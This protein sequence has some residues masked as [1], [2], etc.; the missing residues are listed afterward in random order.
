MRLRN[1]RNQE[2]E[3]HGLGEF[4]VEPMEPRLLLS[5]EALG[6]DIGIL[7][8][9][10]TE[11]PSWDLAAAADWTAAIVADPAE[12]V[13]TQDFGIKA[14]EPL[15]IAAFSNGSAETTND[16]N[17]LDVLGAPPQSAD[18]DGT[19]DRRE[20][21]F[22]DLKVADGATLL[23]DLAARDG[24]QI[25]QV[26][27]LNPHMDGVDQITSVL[28]QHSQIDA[29]HIVTHGRE[30]G[31]QLGNSWLTWDRVSSYAEAI[32]GWGDALSEEADLL[33]YGCNLAG[34]AQG[35]ALIE[36][37][38]RL[39]GADVAASDDLTGHSSLGGDWNLE[40]TAGRIE[41]GVAFSI[42]AQ[43]NWTGQ[44]AWF[45]ADTGTPLGGATGGADLFVGDAGND[46]G[47]NASGG[48]DVLYG[49]DG[50]DDLDGSSD[51]DLLLGG[52]GIDT[53]IGQSGD[54]I[55]LGG[56]GDDSL[57]GG[58]DNDILIG[59]GGN[60]TLNGG[61]ND[62]LFLFSGAQDGDVYDVDG[63][64]H[65]DTIDV[66]E[67]GVGNVILDS[68]TITVNLGGGQSFV[69]N[70][71]DVENI[72]RAE[73]GGNRAAQADAGPDQAVATSSLVT[74]DAS[75]SSDPDLDA[76]TYDWQQIEGTSWVTLSDQTAASPTFT[77]PASSDVLTFAV[78]VSDGIT[79]DVDIV[80][81][82][83][84]PELIWVD[85][86]SGK[87]QGSDLDGSN[88][89]DLL[90]GL[91]SP[92]SVAVDVQAGKVY[93]SDNVLNN[94]QRA[95]LDGTGVE[96]I[97]VSAPGVSAIDLNIAGGKIYWLEEGGGFL[98]RANLDGTAP[99]TISGTPAVSTGLALDVS[100]DKIYFAEKS[101]AQMKQ[102]SLTGAGTGN[103]INSGIDGPA[104][105]A[106]DFIAGKIYWS[107]DT[108][109]EILRANL[110]DGSG[111]E[112]VI[113]GLGV[114][115][116]LAVDSSAGKIYW[117]DDNTDQLQRANLDGTGI[118]TLVP[119][120]VTPRDVDVVGVTG[121]VANTAPTLTVF[122]APVDATAE[123]TEVEVTFA[124]LAAQG[125]E[126]DV[127][128]TVDA[129]VVKAVST[130]TLTIGASAGTATLW[131]A[132]TNDTIDATNKAYWAPATNA[133]GTLNAFTAV[134]KDDDGAESAAPVQV[135]VTVSDVNDAP[136]LA[137]DN[138]SLT[139]IDEDNFTSGG[140]SVAAIVVDGSITDDDGA[141]V[142][143]IAITAVDESNGTWQYS[144]DNGGTW[145]DVDN[146]SLAVNHALLLDGT[147][148]GVSTQRLRFVPN[149]DYTGSAS[150]TFRA[151]D[152]TSG[153]AGTYADTST[154]GDPSA[155]SSATDT[156]S[157]TINAVNDAPTLSG[158]PYDLGSTDEDTT[159]TGVQ[160]STILGG[161]TTG[162][163]DGDTLGLAIEAASGN[164]TWQYSTD[165]TDGTDGTWTGFG[166][167]AGNSALL[168]SNSNWL[169][170]VPDGVNGESVAV[171][172]H[173]WDGATGT[174]STTVTPSY[175]DPGTGGS[176]TAYS[177]TTAQASL[178]VSDMNDP[179][180]FTAFVGVVDTTG[181]DTEVEISFDDL[182]TWG[183]ENDVDGTVEAFVVKSLSS[184]SLKIGAD[185]ASAT[186]WLL[187]IN[188]TIDATT[189]AYWTPDLAANG[190][191]N[192]FEVVAKD[193]DNTE[194]SIN[195]TAQVTVAGANNAPTLSGGLYDLGAT[196]EDTTSTGVR[197]ATI[198]G[199]LTTG[200]ADGDT[201]GLAIEAVNGNGTW[202]YSTDSTDG[203]DGN[204]SGF[205]T[206]AGNSALLLSNSSWIRYVPDGVDG[207]TVAVTFHA[208]DGTTG[209]ASTPGTA[210]YANPGTGGG[211][212][213]YSGTT[214]QAS[215]TVSDVNDP[216]T[217]N[218]FVGVVDMTGEDTEV[219]ITF[220]DLTGQGDENDIDGTVDAF[221]VQG[222]SSG[223]LRIGTDAAS[224]TAF[225]AG[226]N[227][228]IGAGLNAYWT[229]MG[230]AN[231]TLDAFTVKARDDGGAL[232]SAAVTAQVT[233]NAANDVPVLGNNN[234][235][236]TESAAVIFD[237]NM[238]SATDVDNLD[239]G[240]TF[241]ISAV[242]G[243]K[244]ER[245]STG[246]VMT[247]FTQ[248]DITAGEVR[249]V[250]D[251]SETAPSYSV[252]VTDGIDSTAAIP[253]NITFTNLNDPPVIVANAP[254]N[255]PEEA[256]RTIT[257]AYLETIDP[258]NSP[259]QIVYTLTKLPSG[260]SVRLNG[261]PLTLGQT[262]TQDDINN[263]RVTYRDSDDG[264][265]TSFEMTV[266]DGNTTLPA[267]S[268][269]INGQ[270]I[271]DA[272]VVSA[273]GSA[274]N[275]TE[276]IGL[277]IHGTGFSVSD[278][279]EAGAGAL[280]TLS[281]GEGTISVV[282]GN[283]G[284]S[285][286]S[287]DGTSTVTL[288]GSIAQL[289][290][291]LTGTSTGTI[292]YLNN[293]DTP[294][295]NTTLTVTV[296]DQGNTGSDPGLTGDGNSEEGS[297]SITIN[298]ASVNDAPV[299][300]DD[301]ATVFE[302]GTVTIDLPANDT[303][304]DNVLDPT[305]ITI[306]DAPANGSLV[307]N[308]DG[309]LS[310]THDGSETVA[311]SFTYTI[312]DVSGATSN[313][314]TV[315]LTIT[316]Q[317][318]VPLLSNPIADQVAVEDVAFSFQFAA[319][320]FAD[321]D[322]N[323][324]LNYTAIQADGSALPAWLSFDAA[325]RTFSG[326]PTNDDV[327]TISIL[328]TA[329]DGSSATVSDT[330]E[331]TV[332]NTNDAPVFTSSAEDTALPNVAYSHAITTNDVDFGDTLA[333]T[334]VTKPDWLSLTDNEDGTAT[335][336]G[337]PTADD[338]GSHVV[339]LEVTD[340]TT[341]VTQNFTLVVA[342][343]PDA[344]T[345]TDDLNANLP[346]E[347]TLM[348]S[349]TPVPGGFDGLPVAGSSSI[350]MPDTTSFDEG[351]D[352]DESEEEVG[353]AVEE[354]I[355]GTDAGEELVV[356]EGISVTVDFSDTL[357]SS[358]DLLNN[359]RDRLA[360]LMSKV[361]DTQTTQFE[362]PTAVENEPAVFVNEQQ[363]Q[364][365]Y[366]RLRDE[367][368]QEARLDAITLGGTV[369]VSAGLSV[370]YVV[371]LI[372][373]GLLAST[374]LASLPAWQFLDPLPVLARIQDT[375]EDDDS[376]EESLDSIIKQR[377]E[378][379]D[380]EKEARKH[381]AFSVQQ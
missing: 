29:V 178:T 212:T 274:L 211:S 238:L 319:E 338:L 375:D 18:I 218:A 25:T 231:G 376:E 296:N 192:A 5:A 223:T 163:A 67:F 153:S 52:A 269:S 32:K 184:G 115:F 107:D 374:V 161:L 377:E 91:T 82:L 239:S 39:S 369:T 46:T 108:T 142:E 284:V 344:T 79:S 175:A 157:I 155:F 277:A 260:G 281:V 9:D 275:A 35:Q 14:P 55:L 320:T 165:S 87:I 185:A 41:A 243:G 348:P 264:E 372:R 267:F 173:A 146:G 17:F 315:N 351:D 207:E 330:F 337:I 236:I 56:L 199:G 342:V 197:V 302:N 72:V 78:T 241:N 325:T 354:S 230:D 210:S 265:T 92:V 251:G 194:S 334:A 94:I 124:D 294:S 139:A 7:D 358:S 364:E 253:A 43:Q 50:D 362:M 127:D 242:S 203:T 293:S 26:H 341:T 336:S 326:M 133:N 307:N 140:D 132:G 106:L 303:D 321:V 77:A 240:L 308:G 316:P 19:D 23:A 128:G 244:F 119:G 283:S 100:G 60:D 227:D 168:L 335:I 53:L 125:D 361:S 150:L 250:H 279:D 141:A 149:A 285:V 57:S 61:N 84:A 169:R 198:L 187:G 322:G 217:L 49:N 259:D 381:E 306:I 261:N 101:T 11:V 221:V 276:Q 64:N 103:L 126:A 63:G 359:L 95:N 246:L 332:A 282:V 74:L 44:L 373:G 180:T 38:A 179:P 28:A 4:V 68:G 48:D 83:V 62:D 186:P 314:A 181:E 20:I 160:V 323:D 27:I 47:I 226:T 171:T 366:D 104:D 93:W 99:E 339:V 145:N 152:Q 349:V 345:T 379:A 116:G 123:D 22:L 257:S 75:A 360:M 89:T 331:L 280:A 176:S 215:L 300:N 252:S 312:D 333:I 188:D 167:V 170:Y 134:A 136:V 288:S 258:D 13:T 224:A 329:E 172:F 164:G 121:A 271:N 353:V 159:S 235:T 262:F 51:N 272:P 45:N 346:S 256:T 356:E 117:T 290:T 201:L 122:A 245:V 298:I 196:D 33:F 148:S 130:G 8:R 352:S 295:S 96:T 85:Q 347:P 129:F 216:P 370:G 248:A 24:T 206:V 112:T 213:A 222:V 65:T 97:V 40:Y 324:S 71:S 162:D 220:A 59:D 301:S 357:R 16:W 292:T 118:E 182:E 380:M 309:T 166:S 304:A 291:L 90:T 158:G 3:D 109:G 266:S 58:S 270:P 21:V 80:E 328:V 190:T 318:D 54:D 255:V 313:V 12:D 34:S 76:L 37:V 355:E 143:S 305:S 154:A 287:G 367:I 234:L 42:S 114:P 98:K 237:S 286:D 10:V 156:A 311:D 81:I 138:P 378:A 189:K 183:N 195:V 135:Q 297:N 1:K 174:A 6:V 105:I 229:P 193:N 151:W 144:T 36:S 363:M 102:T 340:G 208:W 209:T 228:V 15:D 73:D 137:D 110:A 86:A 88:V 317:N 289:N 31:V 113:S 249:F 350:P 66:S 233:A 120:I 273:P 310:Y 254:L 343:S 200:D 371:W 225:A 247:V 219:E 299:A 177:S 191:L 263:N 214:A 365:A 70:H 278:L 202:Q 147:L 268:F 368:D 30:G 327:G 131:V 205:G 69:I 204:W 232:S 2:L 111:I